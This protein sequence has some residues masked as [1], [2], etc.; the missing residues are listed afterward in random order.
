MQ[1]KKFYFRNFPSK[2]NTAHI[3]MYIKYNN[4][5]NQKEYLTIP[6]KQKDNTAN[7]MI[8]SINPIFDLYIK[9]KYTDILIEKQPIFIA[10]HI[11]NFLHTPLVCVI[12]FYSTLNDKEEAFEIYYSYNEK[13]TLDVFKKSLG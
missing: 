13:P 12:D 3:S 1:L 9:E 8:T 6:V 11:S 5:N 10:K 2:S 4:I 7:V